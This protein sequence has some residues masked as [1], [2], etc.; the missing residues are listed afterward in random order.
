[1]SSSINRF[2]LPSIDSQISASFVVK[3]FEECEIATIAKVSFN[4]N[5]NRNYKRAII[6]VDSWC[7]SETAWKFISRLRCAKDGTRICYNGDRYWLAKL[8]KAEHWINKVERELSIYPK[9]ECRHKYNCNSDDDS[10]EIIDELH[11][12]FCV[13]FE[14]QSKRENDKPIH[15]SKCH[16]YDSHYNA[17]L[18]CPEHA[19]CKSCF[20]EEADEACYYNRNILCCCDA[21]DDDEIYETDMFA[22]LVMLGYA[23]DP[24]DIPRTRTVIAYDNI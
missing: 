23:K 19:F 1:M 20:I 14:K 21:I 5:N 11:K 7:D 9:Q 13:K 18:M 24:R 4:Y 8:P 6:D 16:K 10:L 3:V 17:V 15:C 22:T 2:I 12:N